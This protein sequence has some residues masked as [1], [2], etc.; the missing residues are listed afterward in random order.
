M[1]DISET[2]ATAAVSSVNEVAV[3]M[4]ARNGSSESENVRLTLVRLR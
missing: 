1:R 4:K 2:S 3:D